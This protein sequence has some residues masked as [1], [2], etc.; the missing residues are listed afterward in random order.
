MVK[1]SSSQAAVLGSFY[2]F[3]NKTKG[4]TVKRE[5]KKIKQ[6]KA[7]AKPRYERGTLF[8]KVQAQLQESC[9]PNA[10]P[11]DELYCG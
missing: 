9:D 1:A 7:Y 11:D 2:N 8:E 3:I 10:G 6:K 4:D 5:M